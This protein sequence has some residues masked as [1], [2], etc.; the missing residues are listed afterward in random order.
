MEANIVAPAKLLLKAA[1]V[2]VQRIVAAG[3]CLEYGHAASRY[4]FVPPNAPL[5]PTGGYASSKAAGGVLLRTIAEEQNL[6]LSYARLFSVYGD[7]QQG[8]NLWPM[9]RRAALAGDDLPLTP[10]EQ[11]RDFISVE[12]VAARL[13]ALASDES[14]ERGRPRV[15]NL[16]TGH[17]QSVRQ[18]AEHWWKE[19]GAAGRLMFGSLPYRS[20]EVMRYVAEV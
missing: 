2:G 8:Q 11:I 3:S 13:L 10:G 19:F 5:E 1:H 20:D 15:C 17:P 6:R 18:F 14:V 12:R 16:G 7:G 4:E 9:I